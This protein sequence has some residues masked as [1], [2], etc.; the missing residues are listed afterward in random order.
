MVTGGSVTGLID[1]LVS[2][3]WVQREEDPTTAACWWCA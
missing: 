3:G 2:E 1:K